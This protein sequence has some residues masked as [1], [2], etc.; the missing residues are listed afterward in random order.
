MD[1]ATLVWDRTGVGGGA[2]PF[3]WTVRGGAPF[4]EGTHGIFGLGMVTLA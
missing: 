3:L 4:V 2:D 1:V